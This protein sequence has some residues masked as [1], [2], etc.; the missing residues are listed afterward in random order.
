M[1]KPYALLVCRYNLLK[2]APTISFS[3]IKKFSLEFF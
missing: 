3:G 2:T 1:N